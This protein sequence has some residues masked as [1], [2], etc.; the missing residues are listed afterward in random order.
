MRNPRQGF[1]LI[2][3]LV[4]IA[5]IGVLIGLLLPAVQRVREAANRAACANNL[6]QIALALHHYHDTFNSFPPGIVTAES[7]DLPFGTASGFRLLLGFVE[8]GNLGDR[9]NASLLWYE[10]TNVD[11]VQIPVPLYFCPSNRRTGQVDVHF[12]RDPQG[13]PL[14]NPVAGDYLLCKGANGAVCSKTQV[15]YPARGV[16]DVNT[17]TRLLDIRDGTASTFALGEG[18]GGT[19]RYQMRRYYPD[20]IPEADQF[21]GEVRFA[22]QSWAGGPLAT[23]ALRS[24]HYL[25]GSTIGVTAQ[26]GGFTP[27][28]DEPMNHPLV[29][30]AI[31]YNCGC[32]NN[33]TEVRQ[34][35]TISG[36]RSVHSGGCNFACCDGSVRFVR[37]SIQAEA[38]RALSTFAGG[39]T[40]SE[41]I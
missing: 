39:E 19:P 4:V 41:E 21:T 36:F 23:E 33:N 32:T 13:R 34:F 3:L 5:I 37:Q 9:W 2:E 11:T 18:A 14:P 22:D 31:D 24:T 16:F 30:G 25:W 35:D 1:T 15:P 12:L 26:R 6:K 17:R 10:G 28:F 40:T 20:T 8:Q 38:Y 27:A 7:D 29:M